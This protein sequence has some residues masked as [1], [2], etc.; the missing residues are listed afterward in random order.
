VRRGAVTLASAGTV[1][2]T[3]NLTLSFALISFF[4]GFQDV[5]DAAKDD[6]KDH[7]SSPEFGPLSLRRFLRAD[8]LNASYV[9]AQYGC[10]A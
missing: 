8:R 6:G 5:H 9:A 3:R 4:N 2:V 10:A 1:R 7:G